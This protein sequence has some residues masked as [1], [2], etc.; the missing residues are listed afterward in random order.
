MTLTLTLT[1]ALTLT[2][3]LQ[4]AY[5]HLKHMWPPPVEGTVKIPEG[6]IVASPDAK[7]KDAERAFALLVQRESNFLM[8]LGVF[9]EGG[10]V[11]V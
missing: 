2:L 7:P 11:D 6:V 4:K 1:L 9:V 5:A 10:C 8:T 3:T